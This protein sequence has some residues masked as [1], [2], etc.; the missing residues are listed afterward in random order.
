MIVMLELHLRG[1]FERVV[2]STL[3]VRRTMQ[4]VR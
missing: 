4:Q 3:I 1:S 2:E